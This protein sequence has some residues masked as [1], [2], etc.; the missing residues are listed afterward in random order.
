MF[1]LV[2]LTAAVEVCVW[3][4]DCCPDIMVALWMDEAL[5]A[6]VWLADT[7]L[8]EAIIT[9][10]GVVRVMVPLGSI[11]G[12]VGRRSLSAMAGWGVL[13]GSF[14]GSLGSSVESGQPFR[15]LL[16]LQGDWGDMGGTAGW[17]SEEAPPAPWTSEPMLDL[18]AALAGGLEGEFNWAKVVPTPMLLLVV[19]NAVGGEVSSAAGGAMSLETEK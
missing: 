18:N 15:R 13:E 16:V 2:P 19:A 14:T 4:M 10:G 7:P 6:W 5:P 11:K 9:G 17:K 1:A 8:G 12:V 3:Y